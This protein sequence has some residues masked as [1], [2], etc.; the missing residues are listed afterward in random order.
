MTQLTNKEDRM[1]G[2]EMK[3]IHTNWEK[4]YVRGISKR[5]RMYSTTRYT[6]D[7]GVVEENDGTSEFRKIATVSSRN[8]LKRVIKRM[9]YAN[10]VIERS[11]P[12]ETTL[13]EQDTN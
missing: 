6:Y 12:T 2:I 8:E 7:V 1:Q 10:W 3:A 4:P 13:E 11:E 9:K 5:G